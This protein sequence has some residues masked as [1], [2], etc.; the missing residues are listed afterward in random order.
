[1]SRK[2]ASSGIQYPKSGILATLVCTGFT[3]VGGEEMQ[4][5]GGK[6]PSHV[7]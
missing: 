6:V 1:M 3:Q 2:Q 4:V 7:R 5:V